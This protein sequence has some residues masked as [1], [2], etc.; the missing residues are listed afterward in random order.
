MSLPPVDIPLGAMRFNSDSHK[1]E[2]WNGES[3]FQVKTF[4]PTLDG[5]VRGV[6]M[7]GRIPGG[8]TNRVEFFT[9]DVASDATDFGD[10]TQTRR[11]TQGCASATRS[12]MFGGSEPGGSS[13]Y[14]RIDFVTFSTTGDA[15][16]FGDQTTELRSPGSVSNAT[17]G[18]TGGGSVGYPSGSQ[19]NIIEFI[20]MAHS[21]NTIDFGDLT[22]AR[23][24]PGTV[25]SPTRGVFAGGADY[26]S[27]YNTIDFITIASQGINAS[28]F[29]DLVQAAQGVAGNC[30]SVTGIF[31]H[32]YGPAYSQNVT[33]I[34]MAST[35]NSVNFAERT[36]IS[37]PTQG[38]SSSTRGVFC[39]G[40]APSPTP[41]TDSM[42]YLAFATGGTGV[43]F[44]NLTQVLAANVTASN[45]HGGLG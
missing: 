2:Y 44:G 25:N 35:G 21:G 32:T 27:F 4:S 24:Y 15:T 36:H 43:D 40:Y 23:D 5:G 42:E 26:P 11:R 45:G 12:F 34:N 30:N 17:R 1:L 31:A 28:D 18:I 3:W 13:G 9:V 41:Y 20:T 22:Q 39:G 8:N 14:N 38:A 33:K 37:T 7:G 10:L 6:T 29:G 19:T 16:D